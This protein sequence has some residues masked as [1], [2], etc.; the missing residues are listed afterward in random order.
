MP[1][2]AARTFV[3]GDQITA[4]VEVYAPE[5]ARAEAVVVADLDVPGSGNLRLAGLGRQGGQPRSREIAFQLDTHKLP[6]GRYVLRI[7]AT[8]PG[9]SERAERLVPFE[10]V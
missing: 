1:P 6:K 8:L 7:V 10:V 9:T 2:S 5:S 4:A 3:T